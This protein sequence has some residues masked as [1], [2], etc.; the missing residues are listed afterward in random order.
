MHS[1]QCREKEGHKLPTRTCVRGEQ[2]TLRYLLLE[3]PYLTSQMEGLTT[4]IRG[5]LTEVVGR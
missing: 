3:E 5:E 1:L 4:T 2:V